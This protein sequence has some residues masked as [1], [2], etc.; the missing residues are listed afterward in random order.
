[1]PNDGQ[2]R[3]P[4]LT[5]AAVLSVAAAIA[6]C[7]GSAD[8]SVAQ[9]SPLT[10][11]LGIS[12]A[13]SQSAERGVRQVLSNL[14]NEGLLRVNQEGRLEP[15]LA[16]RWQQSPDGLHLTVTLR[17]NVRF[18]DGSRVDG[19]VV[20]TVLREV[21]P[22]SLRSIFEDVESISAKNERDVEIRFRRPSPFVAD[23]FIDVP[24]Q[25]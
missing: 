9:R 11:R 25:K 10:L 6:A 18:H 21:L 13:P 8:S 23:S 4:V 19:A 12:N 15:L 17:E 20:A 3:R 16:E 1:M 24:I 22:K 7:R 2:G 5:I 14:S